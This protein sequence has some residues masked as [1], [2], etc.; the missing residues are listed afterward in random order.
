MVLKNLKTV[1]FCSHPALCLSHKEPR[2]HP[3]ALLDL[4]RSPPPHL[5]SPDPSSFSTA[6]SFPAEGTLALFVRCCPCYPLK[7]SIALRSLAQ[8]HR[9]QPGVGKELWNTTLLEPPSSSLHQLSE[10]GMSESAG[11]DGAKMYPQPSPQHPS[12]CPQQHCPGLQ[13]I[14]FGDLSKG[15]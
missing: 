9:G 5:L 11:R 1:R 8:E 6:P 15:C 10:Q 2:N 13:A 7:I 4:P 3:S 12:R 14:G